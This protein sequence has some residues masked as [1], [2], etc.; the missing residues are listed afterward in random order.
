MLFPFHTR[1]LPALSD[2]FGCALFCWP[3][4]NPIIWKKEWQWLNGSK[5][6][7]HAVNGEQ[8]SSKLFYVS[9]FSIGY[10]ICVE[11]VMAKA[12]AMQSTS[13]AVILLVVCF[14]FLFFFSFSTILFLLVI[15]TGGAF[16]LKYFS[17]SDFIVASWNGR[18][19]QITVWD[20][21]SF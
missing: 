17:L 12:Q 8:H 20:R 15:S 2:S 9:F 19:V 7:Q 10:S 16:P 4:E 11:Y 3:T 5:T 21:Y 13:I 1:S 6:V 14:F 18:C